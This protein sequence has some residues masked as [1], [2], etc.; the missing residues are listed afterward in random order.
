MSIDIFP[1]VNENMPALLLILLINHLV[2]FTH[3]F[4]IGFIQIFLVHRELTTRRTVKNISNLKELSPYPNVRYVEI[5]GYKKDEEQISLVSSLPTLRYFV[6]TRKQQ[7]EIPRFVNLSEIR[8]INIWGNLFKTLPSYV[9]T[10]VPVLHIFLHK[11]LISLIENRSFGPEVRWLILACNKLSEFSPKWFEN[12]KQLTRLHL[13]G[14]LLRSIDKNAFLNFTSL[15][16]INLSNN[17]IITIGQGAFS[18]SSQYDWI[19]LNDNYIH[20]FSSKWFR[21]KIRTVIDS[22][23]LA[24][25]SLMYFSR[26]WELVNVSKANIW[27]NPCL[28]YCLEGLNASFFNFKD[29]CVDLED[30]ERPCWVSSKE[31]GSRYCNGTFRVSLEM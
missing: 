9:F 1:N 24:N 8:T 10:L 5:K 14:N 23:N 13:G 17:L 22:I 7:V 11:N 27:G 16:D 15:N 6:L 31:Q 21:K 2:Y 20:K 12:P 4:E 26:N 30:L 25:N 28:C 19:F 3:S 18:G 29:S